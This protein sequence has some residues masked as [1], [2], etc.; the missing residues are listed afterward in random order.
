MPGSLVLFFFAAAAAAH[1]SKRIAGRSRGRCLWSSLVCLIQKQRH[2][3]APPSLRQARS[4]CICFPW[5]SMN[6]SAGVAFKGPSTWFS[7][8]FSCAPI[9]SR[10]RTGSSVDV[11]DPQRGPPAVVQH[12]PSYQPR[13]VAAPQADLTGTTYKDEMPRKS[14]GSRGTSFSAK[15][16]FWSH[17]NASSRLPQISAPYDFRHLHSGSYHG[18]RESSLDFARRDGHAQHRGSFRP[19]ELSIYMPDNSTSPILPHFD[20]PRVMT[21]PPPAYFASRTEEDHALMRQR[22]YTSMSFHVPRRHVVDSSPSAAEDEVP[23]RIPPK[24]RNRMRAHTATDVDA[25]KERV[26][27]AMIEVERLQK[28]IDEVMERQSLYTS[29]R[30]STPHSIA[31]TM[32]ELEPMPSIPA[33]PPVAPSFA[34]RLNSEFERPHTAPTKAEPPVSHRTDAGATASEGPVSPLRDVRPLPPPLPLVLR[35]PLRKKK[36][37]SRVSSWLFPGSEARRDAGHDAV[38]NA[39]K[40][41][42]GRQ[43]FYQCVAAVGPQERRSY[44]SLDSMSTWDSAE[45][46][47]TAPTAWSL[48]STPVAKQDEPLRQPSME[49]SATFGKKDQPRARTSV[50]VAI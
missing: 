8:L 43:G 15:R 34:Q 33:L 27:S 11:E 18:T 31:Q 12:P 29:S 7:A 26:A 17:S 41:I 5:R 48:G 2:S 19:L 42:K 4:A 1:I 46:Q 49:R 32:P 40:A 35:P 45:E 9:L 23:P 30:P 21:P 36:S 24:S 50:G 44:D 25:I 38:T 3:F 14:A 6:D 22:S 20:V 37:F 13:P 39:P 47:Q 16:A 28:Q 10:L